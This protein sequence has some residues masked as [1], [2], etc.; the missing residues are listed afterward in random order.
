MWLQQGTNAVLGLNH[1]GPESGDFATAC[2]IEDVLQA[3]GIRFA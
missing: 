3:L 2:R 1:A